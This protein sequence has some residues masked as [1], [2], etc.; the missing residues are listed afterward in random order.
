MGGAMSWEFHA[1]TNEV[2]EYYQSEFGLVER[3]GGQ[4]WDAWLCLQSETR[5]GDVVK[6]KIGECYASAASAKAAV[7]RA[8]ERHIAVD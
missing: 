8:Y 3:I 2:S 4:G 1:E 5:P 7:V 6:H